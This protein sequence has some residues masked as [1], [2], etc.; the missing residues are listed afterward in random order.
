MRCVTTTRTIHS[1]SRAMIEK[2]GATFGRK[3]TER[4]E[5][6]EMVVTPDERNR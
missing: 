5:L 4:T 2:F 1:A 6:V 3:P